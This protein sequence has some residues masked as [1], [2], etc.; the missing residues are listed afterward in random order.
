MTCQPDIVI[1]ISVILIELCAM[2]FA[3]LYSFEDR[4]S[5][6]VSQMAFRLLWLVFGVTLIAD[7]Y[8]LFR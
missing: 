3:A 1:L 5:P 4:L 2:G 7:W 8:L 6:R